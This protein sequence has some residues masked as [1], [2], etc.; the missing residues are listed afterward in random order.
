[1]NENISKEIAAELQAIIPA[2]WKKIILYAEMTETSYEIFY[3]C[4]VRDSLEPIQCYDLPKS[5]DITEEKIDAGIERIAIIIKDEYNLTL[6]KWSIFT[7]IL[8]ENGNFKIDFD[9][10]DLTDGSY[11]FKK[12]WKVKYLNG[13]FDDE[14]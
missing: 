3:Y 2:D 13:N 8:K 5:Y 9:Y 10:T 1:M 14:I 7:F 11:D 6:D 12:E 4:F